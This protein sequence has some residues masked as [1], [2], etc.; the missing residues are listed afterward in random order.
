[1]TSPPRQSGPTDALLTLLDLDDLG[2]AR[3][4]KDVFV[5]PSERQPRHRVFGGQVLAQSLIAASRTVPEDRAVHSMHGYFL[6]AGDADKSIT[7]GVERLR[8]GRSC[9]AR[10]V[11]AY[12]DGQP[13]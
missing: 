3:T 7:F 6:R 11:H 2:G 1:M 9:S 12:Q 10:Q 5:G 8:D 13:I 4:D